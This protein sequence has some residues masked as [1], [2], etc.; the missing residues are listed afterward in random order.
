MRAIHSSLAGLVVVLAVA[1]GCRGW[2]TTEPPV[3]LN[4]NM[5]T[6]EKGKAYRK[7]EFF[8]DGRSMRTPPAGTVA[9]G[10]LR[11]DD[12]FSDGTEG[13]EPATGFPASYAGN[14][15]DIA[16]GKER[17]GI[18]CAPCHGGAGDGKGPVA[19]KLTVAPPSLHDG[20]LKEMPVGKI[21]QAIKYGVNNGNMGSYAA[22]LQ[23]KERWDVILYVRALQKAKDPSVT[24][25]GT[26]A[27][28]VDTAAPVEEQGAALYKSKG[29]NACHSLDGTKVVGPSFK[30]VYGSKHNTDKGEVTVDDAYLRESMLE[31]NAKIVEGYPPA[32]PPLPLTDDEVNALIAFIKAQQ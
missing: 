2:T 26:A 17:Y 22:Q 24:L 6:Q 30:G 3:H 13:G 4:W 20:R 19:S 7:S 29:C 16:H 10:Y 15:S 23:E 12:H 5:D 1:S 25:G 31:P 32:M 28:K 21:Y 18:Y 27:P 14:A 9:R 8:A 11:E